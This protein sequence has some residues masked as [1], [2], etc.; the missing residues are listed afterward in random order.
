MTR[1]PAHAPFATA[2][3][4]FGRRL[5]SRAKDSNCVPRKKRALLKRWTVGASRFQSTTEGKALKFVAVTRSKATLPACMPPAANSVDAQRCL[6]A[7]ALGG[8]GNP[9]HRP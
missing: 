5:A 2:D 6:L 7:M 9:P 1:L 4:S 8:H 3:A